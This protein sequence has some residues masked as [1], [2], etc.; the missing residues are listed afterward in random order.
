[1]K[2]QLYWIVFIFFCFMMMECNPSQISEIDKEEEITFPFYDNLKGLVADCADPYILNYEGKYYLYGTGGKI[3]IRVYQSDDL[4]SWSGAI[5]AKNGFALDSADVWGDHSFW[6]PEVYFLDGK[7]YMFLS[8]MQHLIV[9]ESQ[10]PLGPFVQKDKKALHPD[11]KEIDSHLFIDSDGK[12]YIYFVRFTGG[13]E[14]W[15]AEMNDDLSA[16]KENTLT[17]CFGVSQGWERTSKEPVARVTE[18]PFMLK[19][20]NLYYLFYSA[21][22]Y[23]SQDY[24]VGYAISE[25]P[26]GPFDKYEENPILIGDGKNIFGTGHHSFFISN[27]G[28]MYIVYH[29]HKSGEAVHPRTTCLDRCGFEKDGENKPDKFLVY[30]PSIGPQVV[31]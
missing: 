18:G 20:K 8:A 17:R 10:S 30:G 14:I 23:Q 19:H 11:I 24:A 9:A 13:N 27:S 31:E 4:A 25:S 5:G 21:N 22:H 29:S 15:M 6:A 12:K 26:F 1:M 2:I 28:Q 7:F 3:G 16:I